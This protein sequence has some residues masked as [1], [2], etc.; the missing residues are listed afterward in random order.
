M[1]GA[2]EFGSSNTLSSSAAIDIK[3]DILFTLGDD[4]DGVMVLNSAGLAA[5]TALA[6]VLEATVEAQAIATNTLI[7]ANATSNSDI[8]MYV[9]KSTNS[10]MVLWADGS[11]GNT[12]IMAS[13]GASVDTYIAGTK[14]IDYA[15]G[16]L[17]FQQATTLSTSTGALTIDGDD[18]IILQTTGSGGVQVKELF[19]LGTGEGIAGAKTGNTLRAP[20]HPGGTDTNQAGADITLGAGL[21]TGTGDAGTIIFQLPE[22]V[23]SGTTIQ[24]RATVLTMDM[25]ASATDMSF[26]F[27][28][29]TTIASSGTLT[30]GAITL[31]GGITGGDQAFTAVGNMTFTAGSILATGATEGNTLLFKAGGI[32]G[33][34]FITL[35]ANDT[36]DVCTIDAPTMSGTWLASGTVEMPALTLG[37]AVVVADAGTIEMGDVA[38]IKTGTTA[39]D[40]FSLY[41]Y[42]TNDSATKEALRITNTAVASANAILDVAGDVT[43]NGALN[44]GT[45]VTI[46][47]LTTSTVNGE[48][49]SFQ[50]YDVDGTAYAEVA[51]A[52]NANDPYFSLGGSQQNKF[53]NSGVAE[54][55]GIVGYGAVDAVTLDT[56]GDFTVTSSYMKVIPFGGAG[57]TNDSIINIEGAAEGTVIVLRANATV[58]G[59]NDQITITDTGNVRLAGG[60]DMV[61][62]HIDDTWTAIYNGTNW[63]ETSRTTNG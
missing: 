49:M 2:I 17:A 37:G 30:L 14:E 50:A 29:N 56:D 27:T 16:A 46:N 47:S 51:R 63:L 42:N 19:V 60:L 45:N 36:L 41:A 25:V 38:I 18:G 11:T 43:F 44:F 35:T 58:A 61:L 39:G 55:A 4:S 59:G 8:A 3:D 33:A 12:A 9:N 5:D 7:I 62:D 40:Y 24:T 26:L 1:N 21:G 23:G 31:S 10:Q 53:Y 54:L 34:T 6:G 48:Y 22:I 13:S 32:S 57:L 15:T 52:F 20:D 28:P